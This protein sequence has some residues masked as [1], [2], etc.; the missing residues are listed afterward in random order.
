MLCFSW[1]VLLKY[2]SCMHRM[3]SCLQLNTLRFALQFPSLCF[4]Q[5]G[6]YVVVI[7]DVNG[8]LLHKEGPVFRYWNNTESLVNI[9]VRD[10]LELNVD[11]RVTI[12]VS[13][14]TGQVYVPTVEYTIGK[15]M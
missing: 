7:E 1:C 9:E 6:S 10:V 5:N 2:E 15:H 12:N 3:H 4:R 11:Y 14:I 13:V 8:E